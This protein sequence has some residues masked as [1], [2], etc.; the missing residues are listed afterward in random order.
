MDLELVPVD[1]VLFVCV[2]SN[3]RPLLQ[4]QG[5]HIDLRPDFDCIAQ[6]DVESRRFDPDVAFN[7]VLVL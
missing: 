2:V 6:D 7:A 5:Q 4:W 3:H 1:C